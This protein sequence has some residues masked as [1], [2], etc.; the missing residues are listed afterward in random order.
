MNSQPS[1]WEYTSLLLP[2][3]GWLVSGKV[4]VQTLTDHLNRLGEE[5]WELVNTLDTNFRDG[6]TRDVIAIL[7]RP[8]PAS[9]PTRL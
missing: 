9:I 4:D 5:G 6:G 2:S 1:K 7:K 8:L 3:S